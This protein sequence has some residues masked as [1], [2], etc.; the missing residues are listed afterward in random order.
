MSSAN[1]DLSLVRPFS[2]SPIIYDKLVTFI[3]TTL[4]HHPSRHTDNNLASN[5]SCK[6]TCGGAVCEVILNE[7]LAT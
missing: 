4:I 5:Y 3:A 1:Q 7:G 6:A 2:L